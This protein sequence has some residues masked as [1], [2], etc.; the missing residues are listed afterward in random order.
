[1]IEKMEKIPCQHCQT[2]IDSDSKFCKECGKPVIDNVDNESPT[3]TMTPINKK[4]LDIG[5]VF[6]ERYKILDKVG[7]GGFGSVYKAEDKKLNE[8]VCIKILDSKLTMDIDHKDRFITEIKLARKITHPN[9][10]RI[11]D[12]AEI[13]GNYVVTME[14]VDGSSLKDKIKQGNI[15]TNDMIFYVEQICRALDAAQIMGI[16]HRDIKPGNILIDRNDNVKIV[17]FGL[18]KA[19][20]LGEDTVTGA[21]MGTPEYMSPEQVSSETVDQRSD[22]YSLGV[23]MY[24]MFTGQLPFKGDSPMATALKR[25]LEDPI[26]PRKI[27]PTLMSWIDKIVTKMIQRDK[28]KRYSSGGEIIYDLTKGRGESSIVE[29]YLKR[30]EFF[31][32]EKEYDKCKIALQKAMSL[33]SSNLKIL[34]LQQKLENLNTSIETQKEEPIKVSKFKHIIDSLNKAKIFV[35][36]KFERKHWILI[37]SIIGILAFVLLLYFLFSNAAED[38]N[39][40]KSYDHYIQEADKFKDKQRYPEA[41]SNYKYAFRIDPGIPLFFKLIIVYIEKLGY[42][43]SFLP[44][45]LFFLVFILITIMLYFIY[46]RK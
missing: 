13:E 34:E 14:Y 1:V 2:L 45:I 27:N 41:I 11:H 46:V 19:G 4:H 23:V 33:D 16:I 22:I 9:V 3:L 5:F 20:D 26:P 17:D 8:I 37:F 10:V 31:L 24:E 21:I 44:Y 36:E 39:L 35:T 12:F 28:N 43:H 7:E 32:G 30:A 15:P 6:G 42:E 40:I 38:A 29:E 18:A 25:T